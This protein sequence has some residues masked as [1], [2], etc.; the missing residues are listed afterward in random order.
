ML[1][2]FPLYFNEK[3]EEVENDIRNT[4]NLKCTETK[5]KL[6]KQIQEQQNLGPKHEVTYLEKTAK[7]IWSISSWN[8]N[9]LH[10]LSLSAESVQH[11][12]NFSLIF[13]SGSFFASNKRGSFI[14]EREM[15]IQT[16]SAFALKPRFHSHADALKHAVSRSHI[17]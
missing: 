8:R 14:S 4:K 1:T 17:S 7:L 3:K 10:F 15:R 9:N 13:L 11:I 16:K 5:R 12:K 6:L 2:A